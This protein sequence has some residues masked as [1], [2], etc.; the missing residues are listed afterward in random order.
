[1]TN[2]GESAYLEYIRIHSLPEHAPVVRD[3]PRSNG[4]TSISEGNCNCGWT[5]GPNANDAAAIANGTTRAIAEIACMQHLQ[6]IDRER[7]RVHMSALEAVDYAI[8]VLPGLR[9]GYDKDRRDGAIEALRAL[10]ETIAGKQ[11]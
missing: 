4:G 2:P 6:E 8:A 9:S 5:Q 11:S 1:M 7:R 10:R 3:V